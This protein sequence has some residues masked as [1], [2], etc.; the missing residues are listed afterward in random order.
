[1]PGVQQ[2][3]G[4]HVRIMHATLCACTCT[5]LQQIRHEAC[6]SALG[7]RQAART[8]EGLTHRI[9]VTVKMGAMFHRVWVLLEGLVNAQRHLITLLER[10]RARLG[11]HRLTCLLQQLTQL[12][13][14][15]QAKG[16]Y[17]CIKISLISSVWDEDAVSQQPAECS[18]TKPSSHSKRMIAQRWQSNV[19]T[20]L[21]GQAALLPLSKP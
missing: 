9:T 12:L 10:S 5:G 11:V 19:C 16:Q 17:F 13:P 15:L 8:S 1:M 7:V 18:Y 14:A 20:Q 21:K 6:S 2:L 4:Q 3:P